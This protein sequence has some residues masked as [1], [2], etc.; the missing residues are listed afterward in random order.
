V[1]NQGLSILVA[2]VLAA[3]GGGATTNGQ[4]PTPPPKTTLDDAGWGKFHSVR[5]GLMLP[6]PQGHEWKIDDHTRPELVAVH[7]ASNSRV[8]VRLIQDAGELMN[9][10][11]CEEKAIQDKFVK[12]LR[13]SVVEE[14]EGID[15]DGWDV[16]VLVAVEK[17]QNDLVGHVLSFSSFIRKCLW[18]HF[19][20]HTKLE[21][22]E[23]ELSDRLALARTKIL[24]TLALDAF[25]A[26]PREKN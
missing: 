2:I 8:S 17:G 1:A 12:D 18:F 9:R 5:N 20:T 14:Q 11:K 24:G 13:V 23:V 21:G 16:H 7:A 6:L 3:C 19:E 10:M 22:S 15:K 26:V 25:A 4:L